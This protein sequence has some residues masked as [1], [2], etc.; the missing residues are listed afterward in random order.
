[1]VVHASP[2]NYGVNFRPNGWVKR[3]IKMH[4]ISVAPLLQQ[5]WGPS[6]YVRAQPLWGPFFV[7]VAV[8]RWRRH[9]RLLEIAGASVQV[10]LFAD[11]SSPA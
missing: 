2:G 5:L 11:G 10:H 6:H 3:C 7:V 1:M 4:A 8:I 9:Y